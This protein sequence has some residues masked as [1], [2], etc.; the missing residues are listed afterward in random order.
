VCQR[1]DEFMS[2]A[3]HDE[4]P[5]AEDVK[6]FDAEDGAGGDDAGDSARYG[7]VAYKEIQ[8]TIPQSYW[9]NERVSQFQQQQ[10][11][12]F[13]VEITDPTRLMQVQR[14]QA[15]LYQKTNQP[16]GG[17]WTPPRAASQRHRVQ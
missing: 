17:S 6:K 15:A 13:G 3:Q 2:T 1:L 11:A 5:R 4:A 7:L 10:A 14:M 16:S 8:T 12:A 9:V